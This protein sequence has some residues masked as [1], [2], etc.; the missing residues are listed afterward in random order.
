MAKKAVRSEASDV[1]PREAAAKR[2]A[3]P[4]VEREMAAAAI[5]NREPD[6]VKPV[7]FGDATEM[8]VAHD[9]LAK[10]SEQEI[11]ARAYQMYLERG[12]SHGADF[13]DWLRAEQELRGRR[14]I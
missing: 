8:S 3:R 10:P 1:A 11:R 2:R 4:G 9:D 5:A 14:D 7:N 6:P 13:D 12:G